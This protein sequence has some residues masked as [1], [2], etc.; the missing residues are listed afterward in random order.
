MKGVRIMMAK[1]NIILRHFWPAST[2]FA[3]IGIIPPRQVILQ[4]KFQNFLVF[5]CLE[6]GEIPPLP[7]ALLDFCGDGFSFSWSGLF[8]FGWEGPLCFFGDSF[9]GGL[10]SFSGGEAFS[11]KLV[12][13]STA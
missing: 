9:E 4:E 12:R 7:S 10:Y 1:I 11:S 5:F 8:W 2:A 13:F 3:Y 6:K